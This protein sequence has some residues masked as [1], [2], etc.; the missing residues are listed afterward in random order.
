VKKYANDQVG[1]RGRD[2][3]AGLTWLMFFM[4]MPAFARENV[5]FILSQDAPGRAFFSAARDYYAA[6]P[7]EAG[8][9]V[10]TARSLADVRE[11]LARSPLRGNEPWG[12]VRLVAHGS[13]WEGLRVPLFPGG[14]LASWLHLQLTVDSDEFPPL[15]PELLD[16][17]SVLDIESCGLGRRFAQL[18]NF[19][20]LLAGDNRMR[21]HAS[22]HYVWFGRRKNAAGGMESWRRELPYSARVV[23]GSPQLDEPFRASLGQQWRREH[24]VEGDP[25]EL[26]FVAVPVRIE[27]PARASLD[28]SLE[29]PQARAVLR[30]QGI[31]RSRLRWHLD[32]ERVVGQGLIVVVAPEP[33]ALETLLSSTTPDSA[34]RQKQLEQKDADHHEGQRHLDQGA[35]QQAQPGTQADMG[36]AL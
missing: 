10:T 20:E 27:L 16:H 34:H 15:G 3:R 8:H 26:Q 23:P 1:R 24:R 19:S 29:T 28:I 22:K 30:A 4:V 36:G 2:F 12:R 11:F 14:V 9:L 7:G 31:D 13:Q 17:S 21:I 5:T 6:R 33:P 18:I 25:Q 32:G 35:E